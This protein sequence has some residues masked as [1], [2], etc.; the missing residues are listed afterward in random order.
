MCGLFAL[1]GVQDNKIGGYVPRR[2]PTCWLSKLKKGDYV[3]GPGQSNGTD[4][5][6]RM[7]SAVQQPAHLHSHSDCSTLVG[8]H[9]RPPRSSCWPAVNPLCPL[10]LTLQSPAACSHRV[11]LGSPAAQ[12]LCLPSR[13][14]PRAAVAHAAVQVKP[15]SSGLATPRAGGLQP[16]RPSTGA[17]DTW[18]PAVCFLGLAQWRWRQQQGQHQSFPDAACSLSAAGTTRQ[19]RRRQGPPAEACWLGRATMTRQHQWPRR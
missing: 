16:L 4:A 11:P 12:G 1:Q 18:A 19:R 6:H 9:C 3:T 5:E 10:A 7:G 8:S 13:W 14:S 15:A 17:C 2:A